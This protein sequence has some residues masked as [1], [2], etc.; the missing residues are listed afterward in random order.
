MV[1]SF[2]Y[3]SDM[4]VVALLCGLLGFVSGGSSL[5][6]ADDSKVKYLEG[7]FTV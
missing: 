4:A 2:I 5:K 1:I 3:R 6:E 7:V